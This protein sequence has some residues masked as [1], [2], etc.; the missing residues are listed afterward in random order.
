[1]F[2]HC[3]SQHSIVSTA[4]IEREIPREDFSNPDSVNLVN[5]HF[6]EKTHTRSLSLAPVPFREGADLGSKA[7][8]FEFR[9][10]WTRRL[11]SKSKPNRG[12][13]V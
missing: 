7:S 9:D 2:Q 10:A 13:H 12:R 11:S 5:R 3:D 8:S 4:S 6:S 1:M